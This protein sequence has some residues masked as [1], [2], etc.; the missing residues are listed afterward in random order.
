M[1]PAGKIVYQENY[2][3]LCINGFTYTDEDLLQSAKI[4]ADICFDRAGQESFE[5]DMRSLNDTGFSP[6]CQWLEIGRWVRVLPK[7]IFQC[8]SRVL[9]H[10]QIIVI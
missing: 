3:G 4:V 7:L 5:N 2:N 9:S 8:I 6:F 1:L 10:G